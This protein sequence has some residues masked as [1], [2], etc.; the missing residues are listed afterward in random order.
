MHNIGIFSVFFIALAAVVCLRVKEFVALPVSSSKQNREDLECSPVQKTTI[1]TTAVQGR[2]NLSQASNNKAWGIWM[3]QGPHKKNKARLFPGGFRM[4]TSSSSTPKTTTAVDTTV[5]QLPMNSTVTNGTMMTD[6]RFFEGAVSVRAGKGGDGKGGDG[7]GGD[8]KG[9]DGA[10]GGDAPPIELTVKIPMRKQDEFGQW[11]F[12]PWAATF[13]VL[14]LDT[15]F[16]A[17]AAHTLPRV[18]V[19]SNPIR[20]YYPKKKLD[21]VCPNKSTLYAG[22]GVKDWLSRHL[23]KTKA[24]F[25]PFQ[26]GLRKTMYNYGV[27]EVCHSEIY[28]DLV[29]FLNCQILR[30]TRMEGEVPKYPAQQ[31]AIS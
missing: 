11:V 23:S 29:S 26:L 20:E 3:N 21:V 1:E 9:G 2:V 27:S 7:K 24:K 18:V 14:Y 25:R 28:H 12:D 19:D 5:Q 17:R 13:G 31:K 6:L 15:R 8:G 22:A 4:N 30:H 10:G 16:A